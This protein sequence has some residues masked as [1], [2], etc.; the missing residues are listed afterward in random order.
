MNDVLLYIRNFAYSHDSANVSAADR[1]K[2]YKKSEVFEDGGPKI[3]YF[4]DRGCVRPL[5]HLYGYATAVRR[6]AAN[7]P[8][9]ANVVE[10]R[11]RRTDGQTRDRC[12]AAPRAVSANGR[13]DVPHASTRSVRPECF[14]RRTF[15]RDS[16]SRSSRRYAV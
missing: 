3:M 5:R 1:A 12:S 9:A 10:R 8:H 15:C 2:Q 13:A 7:P 16:V 4:P 6:S 11:D 14:L